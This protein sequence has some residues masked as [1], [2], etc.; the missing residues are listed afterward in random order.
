MKT[1]VIRIVAVIVGVVALLVLLGWASQLSTDLVPRASDDWSRARVLGTTTVKRPPA[2]CPA[3]GG[4][5]YVLWPNVEGSL[6]LAR[7]D[8]AGQVTLDRTLPLGTGTARDPQLV[9][10]AGGVLH[11]LWRDELGGAAAIRYVRLDGEGYTLGEPL[12]LSRSTNWGIDAPQLVQDSAGR[13]HAFWVGG[14]GIEHAVLGAAVQPALLIPDGSLP[15]V[16]ASS[17]GMLHLAWRQQT[18]GSSDGIYYAAYDPQ[19]DELGPATHL[20]TLFLRTGQRVEGLAISLARNTAC[21]FWTIED[22]RDVSAASH[23]TCF[24]A[25]HPELARAEPLSLYLG[26]NPTGVATLPGQQERAQAALSAATL[27]TPRGMLLEGVF[28]QQ[29]SV[30][31][32]VSQLM[33]VDLAAEPIDEQVVTA[34]RQA[35]VKPAIAVDAD[36]SLHVAGLQVAGS[37]LYRVIYAST[38]P[39]VRRVYNA[40]T[41][42]DVVDTV[43]NVIMQSALLVLTAIPMLLLWASLPMLGL[44]V[45]HWFSGDEELDRMRSRVALSLA[46]GL[47]IALTLIFPLRVEVAWPP[48]VWV[49][50]LVTAILAGILT[51]RIL[52]RRDQNILFLSF[53]TFTGLYVVLLW[54]A[55]LVF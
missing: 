21:I 14:E 10:D 32:A 13:L 17:D 33:V 9:I 44:I 4:G 40:V 30:A 36:G 38:A 8:Q 31:S 39:E 11:L 52:Q 49:A 12:E 20:A 24:P 18:A 47:E 3:P 19:A 25:S 27:A 26:W 23:Y 16:Q 55:Y 7:L 35:V 6:Q 28:Q 15:T 50:P 37:E 48:F 43:F 53:L 51:W 41:L 22:L 42:F 54:L 34:S 29:N 1:R 5:V 46:I 45:Y 2:L